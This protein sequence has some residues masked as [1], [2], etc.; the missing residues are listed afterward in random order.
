MTTSGPD[1][2]AQT[3]LVTGAS[4]FIGTHLCRSLAAENRVH[5]V[6]RRA[7]TWEHEHLQWHTLDLT[8]LDAT[9]RVLAEVRADVVFHLCSYPHGER[10]IS[11]VPRTLHG[12]V[13]PAVNVLIAAVEAECRRLVMAGS[14]EEP[15][16][17]KL[18]P[19]PTRLPS[20]L[21][22]RTPGCSIRFTACPSSGHAS[23]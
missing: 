15:M 12:E 3:V 7:A 13:V 2:S 19:H 6:S 9:R 21:A 14:M 8:D 10:D 23:S 17:G 22:E 1:L 16:P 11:M 5:A 18:R 4:G 20:L